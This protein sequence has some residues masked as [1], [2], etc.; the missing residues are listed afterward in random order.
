MKYLRIFK[1]IHETGFDEF[2]QAGYPDIFNKMNIVAVSKVLNKQFWICISGG[3]RGKD[4]YYIA[5]RPLDN[6]NAE[7]VR[8]YCENQSEIVEKLEEIRIQIRDKK[9]L[10]QENVYG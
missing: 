4:L 10:E 1:K 5:S 2:Y 7:C 8:D 6:T 9:V 3:F